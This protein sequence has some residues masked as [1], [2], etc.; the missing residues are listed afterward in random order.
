MQID[1]LEK[2]FAVHVGKIDIEVCDIGGKNTRVIA[3]IEDP[4]VIKEIL[5]HLKVQ[6]PATIKYVIPEGRSPPQSRLFAD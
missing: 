5:A 3:C 6:T 2:F 1:C 4:A